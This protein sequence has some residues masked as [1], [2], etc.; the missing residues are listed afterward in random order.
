MSPKSQQGLPSGWGEGRLRT[1]RLLAGKSIRQVAIEAGVD[2]GQLS[3]VERGLQKPSVTF[4]L[5]IGRTLELRDLVK[6]LELFAFP[7]GD[8]R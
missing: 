5:K 4:L 7:P 3:R 6:V 1:A 8:P 2:R